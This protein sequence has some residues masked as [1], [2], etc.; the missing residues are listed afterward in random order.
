MHDSSESINLDDSKNEIIFQV[1]PLKNPENNDETVLDAQIA[2]PKLSWIAVLCDCFRISNIFTVKSKL[3]CLLPP[4]SPEHQD[5][6]TLVLD[7]DETLVHS[8]FQPISCHI[9]LKVTIDQKSTTV[10]VVKRPGLDKFIEKVAEL[11]EVVVFTASLEGY[12]KPLLEILDPN[13]KIA[14]SLYRDSCT[15]SQSG[16]VKDLSRLGRALNKTLIIDVDFI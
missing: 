8:S 3:P 9:T 15:L 16:Y 2:I 10:Y 11:F 5:K 1:T 12:A 4:Q 7:L 14:A 13:H 6:N